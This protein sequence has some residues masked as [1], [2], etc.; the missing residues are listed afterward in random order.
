MVYL[1]DGIARSGKSIIRKLIL[2]KYRI[3]GISTDYIRAML[4]DNLSDTQISYTNSAEGNAYEMWPFIKSFIDNLIQFA[5]EDYVIE[6]DIL[7]PKDLQEYKEN[8]FVKS[9]FVGYCN[10][11][12]E[13]KIN[14]VK[15]LAFNNKKDWIN[16][17]SGNDIKAFIQDGIKKSCFYCKS[18][19]TYGIPYFDL[20][21]NFNQKISKIIN[22]LISD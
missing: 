7:L 6:G 18:C 12:K 15:K 4:S 8:K 17:L 5:E 2:D 21:D 13:N 11:S 3:S 1:I 20:V 14:M 19:K 22:Y 9:C 10:I 16:N